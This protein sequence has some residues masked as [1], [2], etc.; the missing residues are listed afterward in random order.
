[1][2]KIDVPK[3]MGDDPKTPAPAIRREVSP[4]TIKLSSFVLIRT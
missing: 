2:P 1:M 3:E 4:V